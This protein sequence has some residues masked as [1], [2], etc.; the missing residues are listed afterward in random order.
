MRQQ[1][2]GF[3]NHEK[4][5]FYRL[6]NYKADK[7]ISSDDYF[8]LFNCLKADSTSISPAQWSSWLY[9]M[10]VGS[11]PPSVNAFRVGM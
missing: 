9:I 1:D 3:I 2:K 5:D 4:L 10:G 8:N 11:Y 6:T 7:P